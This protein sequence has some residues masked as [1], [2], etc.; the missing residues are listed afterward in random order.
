MPTFSVV[1]LHSIYCLQL[2]PELSLPTVCTVWYKNTDPRNVTF[3][4]TKMQ[5]QL[6][7]III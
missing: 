1:F 5:L 7:F 3:M 4:D 2:S 6:S